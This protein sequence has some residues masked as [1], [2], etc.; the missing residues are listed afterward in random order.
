MKK[1]AIALGAALLLLAV[2]MLK[3]RRDDASRR[4]DV[5]AFDTLKRDAVT[6]LQVRLQKDTAR[7]HKA[8]GQWVTAQDGFPVDTAKIRN[9]LG[10]LLELQNKEIVSRSTDPTRLV[11]Y[12]LDTAQ[13]KHVS[14][15]MGDKDVK[16][17]IGKTSGTDYSSTYWKWEDQKEIYSTPGNFNWE[18]ASKS[19]DW[20]DRSILK[21]EAKDVR[22]VQVDWKDSL[23]TPTHFKFE[24]V[25]D[26]T[27]KLLEPQASPAKRNAAKDMVTRL[28]DISI[29]DFPAPG[30]T[31]LAKAG[32]DNPVFI[33]RVALQDGKSHE[34][35]AGKTLDNYAYVQHPRRNDVVKLSP[36]RFDIFKK[37]VSDLIEADTSAAKAKAT[38]KP[39][40]P[41]PS[42]QPAPGK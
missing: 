32:L 7:L 21:L 10:Y 34:I 22:S 13:A 5:F 41:R 19:V 16:V 6:V 2:V 25:N 33:L 31:N 20:K 3:T 35:K 37:K 39:V 4:A 40:M 8:G 36:W 17:V 14:W 26:S 30:D 24:A 23:G 9:A 1:T 11:E 42:V 18:I 12:G 28:A 29:D 27:F 38:V 15:R